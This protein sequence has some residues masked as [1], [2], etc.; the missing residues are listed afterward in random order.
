MQAAARTARAGNHILNAAAALLILIL[1]L[2]GGYSLWDT[3][4]VYQGAFAGEELLQYKPEGNQQENSTLED[5]Q[6]INPDVRA[7]LTVDGTHIDYPVVQGETNMEYINK[8]VFGEFSLSGSVFLD[9]RNQSDFSDGYNLLYGHHMDNGGIFSDVAE[10]TG[11]DYFKSHRTGT[12]YLSD[13]THSFLIFACVKT[14]AFDSLIFNPDGQEGQMDIF[15]A[16]IRE[17]AVQYREIG[18][19]A[20]DP[21]I[22]LSTCAE[23]ETNG[24]VIIFGRI[25]E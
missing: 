5:L 11:Q 1:L 2:Y 14:D 17:N 24:R 18:V 8:D 23:A 3:V 22:G 20:S 15:L 10:F 25:E 21:I 9:C 13:E 4:M 16:Y 19:T 6:E 12:L 7:W